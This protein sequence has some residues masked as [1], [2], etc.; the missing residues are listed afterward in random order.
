MS[1]LRVRMGAL[2]LAFGCIG[3]AQAASLRVAPTNLDLIAPDNAATLSLRNEDK[4]PINVQVRVFRWVQ[5]EGTERLE[6]TTDV[7]ASPPLTTVAANAEY[8]VRVVCT[9]KTPP[10]AEES[11]RV[12]VDELPSPERR[13]PGVVNLVLRYSIPVFF[14][15]PEAAPPQVSWTVQSKGSALVLTAKNT[16][17]RR[18]RIANLQLNAG[19]SRIAS[20]DGLLGYVLGGAAMQWTLPASRNNAI[21][22]RAF[23]L[24]AQGDSGPINAPVVAQP[25]P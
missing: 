4:R 16:G 1:V 23:T 18:L 2:M 9:S 8:V 6:P 11:Y 5:I 10:K 22:G 3:A 13:Q 7:A 12:V 15:S 24:S 19:A 14:R 17:Q 25:S 21:A 20:R